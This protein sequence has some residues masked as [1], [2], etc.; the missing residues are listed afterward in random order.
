MGVQGPEGSIAGPV[1]AR[2]SLTRLLP[3]AET[4]GMRFF[5]RRQR[6]LRPPLRSPF[7]PQP[8]PAAARADPLHTLASLA[9]ERDLYERMLADLR[10]QGLVPENDEGRIPMKRREGALDACREV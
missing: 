4:G 3:P 5:S 2:R 6:S 10:A 1:A 9:G 8:R 7:W